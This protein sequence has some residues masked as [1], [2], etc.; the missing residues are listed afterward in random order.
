MIYF[1]VWNWKLYC[2]WSP[3]LDPRN[4]WT[5]RKFLGNIPATSRTAEPVLVL[6]PALQLGPVL[7]VL[8]QVGEDLPSLEGLLLAEK[9]FRSL[10]EALSMS[11][12]LQ[13]LTDVAKNY[14]THNVR[15]T[16]PNRTGLQVKLWYLHPMSAFPTG[17]PARC[18]P[19]ES[20]RTPGSQW[21]R[22][23][24]DRTG[25]QTPAAEIQRSKSYCSW[26]WSWFYQ[27]SDGFSGLGFAS[28]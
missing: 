18:S 16:N 8:Q 20:G 17:G 19:A 2:L 26:F 23:R 24:T 1:C 28:S 13:K 10:D 22:L 9:P 27:I 7:Q 6:L 12:C 11:V 25:P 3:T 15:T 4:V 21:F 14:N 5:H